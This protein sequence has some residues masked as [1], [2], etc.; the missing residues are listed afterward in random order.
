MKVVRDSNATPYLYACINET[1]RF[2]SDSYL[3]RWMAKDCTLRGYVFKSGECNTRGV[4]MVDKVYTR[5]E[6][7][8]PERFMD[9]E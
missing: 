1:I 7:F 5:P 6:V 8:E 9:G 3:M 4:H 2:A